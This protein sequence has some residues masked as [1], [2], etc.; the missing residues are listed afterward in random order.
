MASTEEFKEVNSILQYASPVH[1]GLDVLWGTQHGLEYIQRFSWNNDNQPNQGVILGLKDECR[2]VFSQHVSYEL[3]AATWIRQNVNNTG[4][5]S[6]FV[7]AHLPAAYPAND[8]QILID[9]L[10]RIYP[11]NR[12]H[13]IP[14]SRMNR[15][16]EYSQS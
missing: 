6:D 11:A 15:L 3:R 12:V 5:I 16:N 1:K 8:A 2:T 10:R 13:L 4:E 14:Q 9:A 7:H